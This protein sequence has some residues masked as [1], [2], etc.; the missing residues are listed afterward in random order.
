M[1]KFLVT[2]TISQKS[3]KEN[4][5]KSKYL[6]TS[7]QGG[8]TVGAYGAIVCFLLYA[9]TP[10]RCEEVREFFAN[11]PRQILKQY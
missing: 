6:K 5:F 11:L 1:R 3:D 7:N 10:I 8:R 2:V 4:L 9:A